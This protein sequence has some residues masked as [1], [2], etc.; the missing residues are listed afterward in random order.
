MSGRKSCGC[1]LPSTVFKMFRCCSTYGSID[2]STSTLC[3]YRLPRARDARNSASTAPI[4]NEVILGSIAVQR[5]LARGEAITRSAAAER[6]ALP[7]TAGSAAAR[8]RS[9]RTAM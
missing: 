9:E 2:C 8:Q 6:S 1:Q 3:G 5:G 7:S 4:G